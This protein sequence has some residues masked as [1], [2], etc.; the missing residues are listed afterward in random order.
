MP[1]PYDPV[2]NGARCD[3]CPLRGAPVIPPRPA[4]S[5]KL[6][7][8]GDRPSRNDERL[9]AILSGKAGV[10]LDQSLRKHGVQNR[11]QVYLTT[12]ALCRGEKDKDNE[13]AALCC[14]PRLLGELAT[15]V[16]GS[17]RHRDEPS[18]SQSKPP[19]LALGKAATLSILGTKK[20]LYARGF[21]WHAPGIGRAAIK[22][23]EKKGLKGGM[24]QVAAESLAL[25]AKLEGAVVFPT[26]DP[27]FILRADNWKPIWEVDTSRVIRWAL[28]GPVALQDDGVHHVGGL[29][30][31]E[32]LGPEVSLD[33][34]TDGVKWLE[35]RILCVGLSDGV[36]TSV[37]YPWK[38]T[39]ARG[40]S[41]WLRTRKVVVAHNGRA[42]DEIVL[43]QHGVK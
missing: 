35:C 18:D 14:A 33:I 6:V 34:E 3:L 32:G 9:G 4:A 25:R 22:T 20:L 23:A 19:I 5:P 27:G 16:G 17:S 8:V 7:V 36:R 31:L 15:I 39:Y 21:V 12:A 26:V 43:A 41:A 38:R 1:A 24:P 11:D 28:E 42:F 13:R 10:L 2:L 37:I 29:E 40:L 30:V